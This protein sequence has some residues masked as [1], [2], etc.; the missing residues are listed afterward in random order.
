MRKIGVSVSLA[1]ALCLGQLPMRAASAMPQQISPG[2]LLS[3]IHAI[4]QL[5]ISVGELAVLKGS[6]GR[7]RAYGDLLARDHRR[8]DAMVL[9]YARNHGVT[10]QPL[11]Q[12]NPA[13]QQE[14]D[15]F[16]EQ[17]TSLQ[18]RQ[19]DLQFLAAMEKGHKGAVGMLGNARDELPSGE[20]RSLVGRLVPILEQHFEIASN[21]DIHEISKG[22]K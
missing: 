15:A 5:E 17:L 1:A 9:Q 11:A 12:T 14:N 22:G 4:N 18:G 7:V 19:F 20:L 13:A 21:L 10:V 8:A 6:T 2:T 3:N 16:V